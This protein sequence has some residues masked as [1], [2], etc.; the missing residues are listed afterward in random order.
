MRTDAVLVMAIANEQTDDIEF[1]WELTEFEDFMKSWRAHSLPT[2]QLERR[3]AAPLLSRITVDWFGQLRNP[4]FGRKE[5]TNAQNISFP[6]VQ[7][8]CPSRATLRE[9]KV[10]VRV[11]TDRQSKSEGTYRTVC[12]EACPHQ[13]SLRYSGVVDRVDTKFLYQMFAFPSEVP[14]VRQASESP[15]DQLTRKR[16]ADAA[17]PPPSKKPKKG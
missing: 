10:G 7:H 1:P 9:P 14:E 3:P 2:T 4:T 11:S 17:L 15:T 16:H 13:D 12:C 6:S 8:V 5:A